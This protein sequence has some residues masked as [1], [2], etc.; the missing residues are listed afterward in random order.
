MIFS[1]V[2]G[3][4]KVLFQLVLSLDLHYWSKVW[5]TLLCFCLKCLMFTK[6]D[7]I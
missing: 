1:P 3:K 4:N 6:A 7:F 2:S 5:K